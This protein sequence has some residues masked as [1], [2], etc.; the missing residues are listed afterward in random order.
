MVTLFSVGLSRPRSKALP[1]TPSTFLNTDFVAKFI[2]LQ[3]LGS[4]PDID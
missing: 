4:V 2:T 1:H 3:V